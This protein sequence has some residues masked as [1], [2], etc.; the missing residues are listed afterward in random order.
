MKNMGKI[1]SKIEIPIPIIK[2]LDRNIIKQK[3]T[4]NKTSKRRLHTIL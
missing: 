2:I 3:N 4:F 1:I